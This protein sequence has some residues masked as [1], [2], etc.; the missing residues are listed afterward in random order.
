MRYSLQR[1][2]NLA[3][4]WAQQ[5]SLMKGVKVFDLSGGFRSERILSDY[6][7]FYGFEHQSFEAALAQAKYGLAEW[8]P[9]D[10]NDATYS[11]SAWVA[12][13]QRAYCHLKPI[14]T[15]NKLNVDKW[16]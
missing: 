4:E 14:T 5:L 13:L 15:A 1:L 12:I 10:F 11:C 7:T 16:S 9:S 8:L 6:P 3:L 2:M